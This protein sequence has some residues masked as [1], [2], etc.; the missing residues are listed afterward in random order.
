MRMK[1]KTGWEQ[2]LQLSINTNLRLE[3]VSD[4]RDKATV[5][6]PMCDTI[7]PNFYSLQYTSASF[8]LSSKVDKRSIHLLYGKYTGIQHY[9]VT[10]GEWHQ[11]RRLRHL[12]SKEKLAKWKLVPHS[13]IP[14]FLMSKNRP[15][16]NTLQ[17]FYKTLQCSD[18]SR[19]GASTHTHTHQS[20]YTLF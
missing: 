17:T 7:H 16:K 8:R 20:S 4:N 12:L 19:S 11:H 13:F 3:S 10:W 1:L 9:D 15:P 5:C 18:V 6:V 2:L 14:T